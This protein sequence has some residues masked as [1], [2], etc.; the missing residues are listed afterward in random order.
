[1]PRSQPATEEDRLLEP[2]AS[3]SEGYPNSI[4]EDR[5]Y[6]VYWIFFL[7]GAAML[8]PWNGVLFIWFGLEVV[9]VF[10]LTDWSMFISSVTST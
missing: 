5:F 2:E 1:M 4:A 9:T 10:F 7:Q 6:L 8:L 3:A